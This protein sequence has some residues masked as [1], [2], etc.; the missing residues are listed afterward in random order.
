MISYVFELNESE[1]EETESEG[2]LQPDIDRDERLEWRELVG[3]PLL[4][5]M[6]RFRALVSR[7]MLVSISV[8]ISI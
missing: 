1:E 7:G 8:S 6:G 5:G 2:E 3:E 4:Y